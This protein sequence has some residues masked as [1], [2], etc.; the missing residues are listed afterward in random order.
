VLPRSRF[1]A[2]YPHEHA[3]LAADASCQHFRP[4]ERHTSLEELLKAAA[5]ELDEVKAARF[6]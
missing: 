2:V 5:I 1:D 4:I 3:G 6:P